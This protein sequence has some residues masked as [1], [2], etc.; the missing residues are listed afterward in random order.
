MVSDVSITTEVML[1]FE[2]SKGVSLRMSPHSANSLFFSS[3]KQSKTLLPSLM[4]PFYSVRKNF[5]KARL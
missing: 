1:C 5:E 3:M 2:E 4:M